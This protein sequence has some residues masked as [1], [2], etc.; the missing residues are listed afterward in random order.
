MGAHEKIAKTFELI[1]PLGSDA[2]L[3]HTLDGKEE[4]GRLSEFKLEALS[5]RG[6]INPNDIL[7][8]RISIK[9]ELPEGETRYFTAYV[10]KF[11]LAGMQGRYYEYKAILNPWF[12]MLTRTKDC[13]IYQNKTVPQIIKEVF[14]EHSVAEYK[15]HLTE[16]YRQRDYCVQ[17]RES[18]FDF[19]SRLMEEEGI[20]YYFEHGEKANMMILADGPAAHIAFKGYEQIPFIPK[21]TEVRSEIEYINSWSCERQIQ[22]GKYVMHDFDYAKPRVTLTAEKAFKLDHDLSEYEIFDYPGAYTARADGDKYAQVRMEELHARHEIV[23]GHTNA[24]GISTGYLFTFFKHPRDDQ[25]RQYLIV[26]ARYQLKAENYESGTTQDSVQ[27][28]CDF[29]ALQSKQPFRTESLTPIPTVLGP[30]TAIVVGPAGDEIFMDDSGRVKV[31][32]HWDRY[33]KSDENSSCWLR[34]SQ[35]WAGKGWGGVSTPRIGQEVIVDFMEGDPD[36][37]IITG[38]VYNVE[39]KQPLGGVVSGLKSQTHKGQGYNEMSMDD[40]AGNEK[41]TMHGQ[42]DMSTT[43]GNDQTNNIGNNKTDSVGNN[44]TDSVGVDHNVS[45]GSNQSIQI[46]ANRTLNVDGI[47]DETVKANHTRAVVGNYSETLQADATRNINGKL[48][49]TVNG[50]YNKTVNSQYTRV[51]QAGEKTSVTGLREMVVDGDH[52]D[53]TTGK[54]EKMVTGPTTHYGQSTFAIHSDGDGSHTSSSMLTFGVGEDS[55]IIID[56]GSIKIQSKG[57]IITIDSGGVSVNG[58]KISLNG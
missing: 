53:Q 47:L 27:Y 15:L 16:R 8:K 14:E 49:H 32:F 54:F 46:G 6:D 4:L 51:M 2:L 57:S 22:P 44:R 23:T 17:Y 37:P 1:T 50:P 11:G 5:K 33:G 31:Q 52:S 41:L 12:W 35:P 42:K 28:S 19:V 26:S 21:G 45:V 20:Y 56:G 39:A 7:G 25:N 24:R 40:T 10:T 13:R 18:D 3:F 55:A 36:L 9:F 29:T 30:Q 38:R 58:K 43:V 48:D 34:V